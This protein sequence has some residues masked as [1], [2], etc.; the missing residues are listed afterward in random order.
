[1][2]ENIKENFKTVWRVDGA[3]GKLKGK[4]TKDNGSKEWNKVKE[5][6][7]FKMVL[8]MKAVSTMISLMV[9]EKWQLVVKFSRAYGG[10]AKTYFIELFMISNDLWYYILIKLLK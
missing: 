9:K 2:E 8:L 6:I 3:F 1:M 10:K 4:A 7:D 5:H